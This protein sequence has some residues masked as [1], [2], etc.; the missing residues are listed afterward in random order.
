MNPLEL[1]SSVDS[2]CD[3]FLPGDLVHHPINTTAT[4]HQ[5]AV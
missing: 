2:V 4:A 1:K 3:G 5:L